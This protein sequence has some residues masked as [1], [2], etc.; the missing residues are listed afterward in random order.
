MVV[1][2]VVCAAYLHAVQDEVRCILNSFV[3][4]LWDNTFAIQ[5]IQSLLGKIWQGIE[6]IKQSFERGNPNAHPV[7]NIS[8]L[9]VVK[10][11]EL[12]GCWPRFNSVW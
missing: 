2:V 8:N 7:T 11:D 1:V 6:V 3:Y 5:G 9:I 10:T 12:A 4:A